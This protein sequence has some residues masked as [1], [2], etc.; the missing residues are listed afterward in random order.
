MALWRVIGI[1]ILSFFLLRIHSTVGLIFGWIACCSRVRSFQNEVEVSPPPL[2]LLL[3]PKRC[4]ENLKMHNHLGAAFWMP[5][6]AL[7]A[8][9]HALGARCKLNRLQPNI[10]CYRGICHRT[11]FFVYFHFAKSKRMSSAWPHLNGIGPVQCTATEM[12]KTRRGCCFCYCKRMTTVAMNPEEG[13]NRARIECW[14]PFG[15][16]QT[17]TMHAFMERTRPA[18]KCVSI[19]FVPYTRTR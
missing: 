10:T 14:C 5:I 8:H 3:L 19:I 9:F 16:H 7:Y 17:C 15:E 2:P 1:A 18:A 11:A 13:L 4:A 6:A 12:H